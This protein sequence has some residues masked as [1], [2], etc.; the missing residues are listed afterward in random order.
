MFK[1]ERSRYIGGEIN[2]FYMNNE[3]VFLPIGE[4]GVILEY[5]AVDQNILLDYSETR[6][7]KELPIAEGIRIASGR[8]HFFF[9]VWTDSEKIL[10]FSEKSC[11]IV[12]K[13]ILSS[14]LEMAEKQVGKLREQLI[15]KARTKLQLLQRNGKKSR[16]HKG[17]DERPADIINGI[18]IAARGMSVSDRNEVLIDSIESTKDH[19][20]NLMDKLDSIDPS[21]EIEDPE[22]SRNSG[23]AVSI[24]LESLGVDK[25]LQTKTRIL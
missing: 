23:K 8:Y 21:T 7:Y 13:T 17:S 6:G 12:E 4:E 15:R 9:K 14:M 2:K 25:D 22:V 11:F 3:R 1:N 16:P 5:H 24:I 10:Y 19:Y 18:L 20:L